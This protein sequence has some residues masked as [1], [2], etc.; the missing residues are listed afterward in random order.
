[1]AHFD[2][3]DV[4]TS[5]LKLRDERTQ[6][7][8]RESDAFDPLL[9]FGALIFGGAQT[10]IADLCSR[11]NSSRASAVNSAASQRLKTAPGDEPGALV[12]EHCRVS[13]LLFNAFHANGTEV[14]ILATFAL[15]PRLDA[16]GEMLVVCR[17]VR[18]LDDQIAIGGRLAALYE[19]LGLVVAAADDLSAFGRHRVTD[20]A[21]AA[22]FV[23][24]L[25]FDVDFDHL[26]V[27][28][29]FKGDGLPSTPMERKSAY[30]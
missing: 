14:G 25:I 1:M 24:L 18:I 9:V 10:A 21:D 5:C 23:A 15:P 12:L 7:G 28:S 26:I 19:K 30:L 11:L 6:R 8:H 17:F 2:V 29:G 13:L 20:F 16:F 4:A 27:S 22:V 3:R